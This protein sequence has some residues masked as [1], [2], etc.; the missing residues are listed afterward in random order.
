VDAAI[1]AR[2]V[3]LD[4][5]ELIEQA[6]PYGAGNP[7]PILALP[8][9]RVIYA[10]AAGSD[11]IRCTL[12]AGDGTRIKAI[13]FRALGTAWGETILS[14]RQQPLHF[15]GRLAVDDWNGKRSPSFQIE[16][17]AAAS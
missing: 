9:H 7:P 5:I 2:G 15:A 8:A 17:V 6:G 3:T 11:H 12:A 13:A 16:D 1:N 10:D 14:E 4:L